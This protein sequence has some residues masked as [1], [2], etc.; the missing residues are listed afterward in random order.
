MTPRSPTNDVRRRSIRSM[1]AIDLRASGGSAITSGLMTKIFDQFVE[2][3]FRADVA[4]RD[5]QYGKDAP[6]SLLPRTAAQR[7]FDALKKIFETAA[8]MPA[9][10]TMPGLVL[11]VVVSQERFE[12]ELAKYGLIDAMNGPYSGSIDDLLR[13]YCETENGIAVHRPRH[14]PGCAHRL[15]ATVRDRRSRPRRRR[16]TQA[17]PVHRCRP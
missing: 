16:R 13:Q 11:N 14:H 17:P 12:Y 2:D 6:A 5:E 7:R 8:A 9:G 4:A 1:E 10:S 3:E 15:R